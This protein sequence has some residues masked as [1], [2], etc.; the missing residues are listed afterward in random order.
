MDQ[1]SV[2]K[3]VEATHWPRI[4]GATALGVLA[5][6]LL[7]ATLGQFKSYQY[8]GS[9]VTA[10]N[11]ISVNGEGDVFAVPNTADFT[12]TV[13]E[14]AKD[15]KTAQDSATKKSNAIVDYLKAQGI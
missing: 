14:T 7:V 13:Q 10:T 15:V 11:T 5:L 4:M 12:V 6:F 2:D 3:I 9:G 1:Q 8:I